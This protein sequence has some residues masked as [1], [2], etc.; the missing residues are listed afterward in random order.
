MLP[1]RRYGACGGAREVDIACRGRLTNTDNPVRALVSV[2]RVHLILTLPYRSTPS[3]RTQQAIVNFNNLLD[4]LTR[5]PISCRSSGIC[6]YNDASLESKCER[7]CAMCKLDRTMR[8]GMIV[9][10]RAEEG[11]GLRVVF[12]CLIGYHRNFN[13]LTFRMEGNAKSKDSDG[14]ACISSWCSSNE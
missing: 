3:H 9:C 7:C 12:S 13:Q 14:F 2:C 11:R 5:N 4:C 6:S 1:R 8:V 10:Q